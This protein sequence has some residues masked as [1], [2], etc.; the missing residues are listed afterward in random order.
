MANRIGRGLLIEPSGIETK[1]AGGFG[2]RRT[3]F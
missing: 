1:E 3:D 2:K